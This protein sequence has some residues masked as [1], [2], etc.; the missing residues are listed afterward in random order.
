[1]ATA[2]RYIFVVADDSPEAASPLQGF[3][4]DLFNYAGSLR[5][6]VFLPSDLLD[7]GLPND[8]ALAR[9]ISGIGGWWWAPLGLETIIQIDISAEDPFWIVF[10][11][12]KTVEPVSEWSRQQKYRPLVIGERTASGLLARSALNFGKVRKFVSKTLQ[13]VVRLEPTIDHAL[14]SQSLAVRK[15]RHREPSGFPDEGHNI[16]TPNVMALEGAGQRFENNGPFVGEMN[17]AKYVAAIARSARAVLDRRSKI[18]FVDAFRKEPPGP[19]IIVTAPSVYSAMQSSSPIRPEAPEA[20]RMLIRMFQRQDGYFVRT[21]GQRL[22]D[23]LQSEEAK[24]LLRI[25]AFEQKVHTFAVGLKAASSLAATIRLP[26]SVNRGGGALRHL[27][28]HSRHG[29]RNEVKLRRL[30]AAVQK[31]YAKVVASDLLDLIGSSKTG[32]KL[33][34]DA[35]LEWLPIRDLPLSL[36]Y[37]V[38]RICSTPG[39]LMI[40][41]LV[42]PQL[43]KRSYKA[44]QDVLI[45]SALPDSDPIADLLDRALRATSPLWSGKIRL[46]RSKVRTRKEFIDALNSFSGGIFIFDGHGVPGTP[47]EPGGLMI[48]DELL[49]VWSLRNEVRMPPV[50]ILSACDTLPID[51]SHASAA[52]GFLAVGARTV[53][54][55]L[56]PIDARSAAA[57]IA[58]LMH[59]L[60]DYL[61]AAFE[62]FGRAL[63]WTEIISGMLRM[64]LLTDLLSPFA[65]DGTLTEEQLRELHARGNLAINML[66]PDW[67]EIAIDAVSVRT[68]MSVADVRRRFCDTIPTSDAVRYVQLGSPE[69]LILDDQARLDGERP[70][71]VIDRG[72]TY[73][74]I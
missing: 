70:A 57:F 61:P 12:S 23:V 5:N 43:L 66:E 6:L 71:R 20:V 18:E 10:T 38:S 19:D 62:I 7:F 67:F 64:Q 55:T 42:T 26:A 59:R 35:P 54:G 13:A 49:D 60:A 45:V 3:S 40:G 73:V 72:A 51:A 74:A 24:M 8:A 14:A 9:R 1:M 31:H 27:A 15:P 30:F 68:G 29:T 25:R 56:L 69:T 34:T 47:E 52:N 11:S 50:V 32:I 48:G 58:R 63:R 33:V 22:A 36:R 46:T 4:T 16:V 2:I 44:Y 41:E 39:N 65:T 28:T 53:V 21:K 17:D 37:D